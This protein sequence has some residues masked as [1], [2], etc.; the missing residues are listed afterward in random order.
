MT[1]F[2]IHGWTLHHLNVGGQE[3]LDM[4][5]KLGGDGLQF[6]SALDMSP[7]LD[8]GEIREVLSHAKSL[9]LYVECGIPR[10]NVLSPDLECLKL[11]DG[12]YVEGLRAML[13][14]AALCGAAGARTY[15]G[16]YPDRLVRGPEAWRAQLSAVAEVVR[17]LA[18]DARAFGVK[19][20]IETHT[21]VTT[22]ELLRIIEKAGPDVLGV[23]LDTGNMPVVLE[24]PLEA[25]KRIVEHVVSAHL[26][27]C[28]VFSRQDGIAVQPRPLG[29]GLLPMGEV[30]KLLQAEHPDLPLTIEDH[31]GIYPVK[32]MGSG[33]SDDY[34]D[35]KVEEYVA[36]LGHVA[37]GDRR[38]AERLIPAPDA[39]ESIPW[40]D[41]ADERIDRSLKFVRSVEMAS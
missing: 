9:G 4:V 34:P 30:I 11:G 18:D 39:L 38:I 13:R 41:Q 2:G 14:A 8:P 3:R 37:E 35:L 19:I 1:K 33:W 28:V 20:A 15:I 16:M 10:I 27:D 7:T 6:I 32:T 22:F 17:L 24:D 31:E 36:I 40:A 26:K 21:D 5:A 25:V 23:C 12:D 29:G